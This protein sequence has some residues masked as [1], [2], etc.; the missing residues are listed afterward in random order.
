M[1]LILTVVGTISGMFAFWHVNQIFAGDIVNTERARTIFATLGIAGAICYF[2]ASD[3]STMNL[4]SSYQREL[5]WIFNCAIWGWFIGCCQSLWQN[6]R[7]HEPEL[8]SER[9]DKSDRSV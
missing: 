3:Q 9:K 6:R 8:S 7:R 2:F 1:E 5:R 4:I